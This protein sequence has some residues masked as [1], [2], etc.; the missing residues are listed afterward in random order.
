MHKEEEL[1]TTKLK[2]KVN[3]PIL[4]HQESVAQQNLHIIVWEIW[5]CMDVPWQWATHPS[6]SPRR[7]YKVCVGG[8][9]TY[10]V[11]HTD[12]HQAHPRQPWRKHPLAGHK[13]IKCKLLSRTHGLATFLIAQIK[14][15]TGSSFGEESFFFLAYSLGEHSPVWCTDPRRQEE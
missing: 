15:M 5:V 4:K 2:E 11:I 3:T 10:A 13:T 7:T 9:A 8:S 14:Y 6:L 1:G 12:G